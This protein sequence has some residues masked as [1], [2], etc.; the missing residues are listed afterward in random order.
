MPLEL[1]A[2]DPASLPAAVAR[3]AGPSVPP[4]AKM[5]AAKGL[6]PMAPREMLTALYQLS[7]DAESQVARAAEQTAGK[8]PESILGAGLADALD[9]RVLD[10]FF[11]RAR[12]SCS[13][14][15]RM[16]RPSSPWPRPLAM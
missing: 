3:V 5:M 1:V 9:P 12:R 13:I 4:Q 2:L 7:Y 8:L 6:A 11:I 15:R 10:F 16:T 14:R